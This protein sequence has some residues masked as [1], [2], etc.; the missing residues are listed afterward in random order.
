VAAR[1]DDRASSASFSA[2]P[3][4][5]REA[6]AFV[7]DRLREL[8]REG[9]VDV[10]GLAASEL[11]TNVI[12]HA[13]TGFTVRIAVL[14]DDRVRITVVDRSTVVPVVQQA[15]PSSALGRGL[16]LV[17]DMTDEWGVD[18][19]GN[20]DADGPGKAVWFELGAEQSSVAPISS[21]DYDP[22]GTDLLSGP[23]V[24]TDAL[25]DVH[26]GNM[27]LRLFARETVRHRELMREMALIAFGEEGD[28][29]HVPVRLTQLANELDAYT[30]VGAATDAVRDAAIA[31]G[32]ATVDLVY[33]LPPA[34]G[35]ACRRL[36]DL[37]DAAE[38]YCRS[39][40]LLTLAATQP[41]LALR[42]WYLGEVANQID[43]GAPT[44][45]SGPLE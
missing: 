45:W 29:N 39:E 19:I 9:L 44:R 30:G 10:A 40:N 37:L 22:T 33:R 17:A 42:R 12:L 31:R 8:G 6:R 5:V 38:E 28:Q 4:A 41:G 34:V 35:P 13:R 23:T 24:P 1:T 15:N 20:D 14:P 27:P 36:N 43:G 18:R 16:R 3:I 11:A 25:V 26:L 21:T 2:D 7:V 32:D